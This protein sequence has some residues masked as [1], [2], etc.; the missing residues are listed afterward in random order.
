M[1]WWRRTW[2]R[3]FHH[4]LLV[5]TDARIFTR[6]DSCGFE[7]EGITLD[8]VP[9]R[10]TDAE[11]AAW[12]RRIDAKFGAVDAALRDRASRDE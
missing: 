8:I 5:C 10:V 9:R 6:C 1:R 4:R 11:L 2:C 3:W 12:N 7:S